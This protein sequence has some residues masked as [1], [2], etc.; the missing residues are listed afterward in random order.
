MR[1]TDLLQLALGIMP[2][3]LVEAATFDAEKRRLDI[4]IDFATGGRF[5]CPDC[6]KPN[7]PTHDTVK[8]TWR[9]LDFFQHQCASAPVIDPFTRRSALTRTAVPS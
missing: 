2:P 7:C 6:A 5:P 3:W 4:E 9:H 8:K 1:D